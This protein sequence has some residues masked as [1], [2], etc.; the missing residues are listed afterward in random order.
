MFILYAKHLICLNICLNI[1]AD[2]TNPMEQETLL[3]PGPVR[4]APCWE[5]RHAPNDELNTKIAPKAE[6]EGA[7]PI[8]R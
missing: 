6:F 3:D 7:P 1:F 2:V 5:S 4:L 8:D